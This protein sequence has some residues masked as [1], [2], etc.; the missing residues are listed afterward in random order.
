MAINL[1][2]G[3]YAA[4]ISETTVAFGSAYCLYRDSYRDF[5][6]GT[7]ESSNG[8]NSFT[9]V[10]VF[11]SRFWDPMIPVPSRIY[12]WGDSRPFAGYR[13]AIKDLFDMKGLITF[14]GGVLVGKYNLAQFASGADPWEWQDGHHPFNPRGDGWLACSVSSSGGGCFVA[15]YD[16]PGFAISRTYGNRPGPASAATDPAGVFSRYVPGH[17]NHWPVRALGARPVRLPEAH[18]LHGNTCPLNN[19]AAE[20]ELQ[21]FISN[22]TTVFGMT[23]EPFNMTATVSDEVPRY[24]DSTNAD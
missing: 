17:L 15:A 18:S 14:G 10:E 24:Q 8:S 9:P 22:P 19:P 12:S 11:N 6:Y 20:V 16:R 21:A 13:V 4:S 2:A 7:Y 3:P 5:L 23:V 1:I